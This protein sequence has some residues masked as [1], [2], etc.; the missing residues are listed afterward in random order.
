MAK[1]TKEQAAAD[2]I[3]SSTALLDELKKSAMREPTRS[4]P[5]APS[6]A[7]AKATKQTKKQSRSTIADE[8]ITAEL[9]H[10]PVSGSGINAQ[11]R[12]DISRT[13]PQTMAQSLV[14]IA[15]QQNTV[16]ISQ[17]NKKLDKQVATDQGL[18]LEV[19]LVQEQNATKAESIATQVMKTA[20]QSTRTSIE[21]VRLQGLNIDL[22]GE[23]ALLPH[24]Q[25][26]WDIKGLEMAIDN[27]GARALLEPRREHWSL[28]AQLAQVGLQKLKAK[29]QQDMSELYAPEQQQITQHYD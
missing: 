9:V 13:D 18:G 26:S 23:A 12:G 15:E 21:G 2:A 20:Q 17:A 19:Q 7:D 22:A 6:K 29:I 16:L 4:R 14:A 11:V 3:A 5:K 28:K 24:R 8:P 10:A 27:D 1:P 25:D